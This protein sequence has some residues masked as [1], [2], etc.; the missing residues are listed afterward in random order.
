[1][2]VATAPPGAEPGGKNHREQSNIRI[3]MA[4]ASTTLRANVSGRLLS[5]MSATL[6]TIV[7][8]LFVHFAWKSFREK[9]DLADYKRKNARDMAIMG[10]LFSPAAGLAVL[11]AIDVFRFG[12]RKLTRKPQFKIFGVVLGRT[13]RIYLLQAF[14]FLLR[15]VW[16]ANKAGGWDSKLNRLAN[17]LSTLSSFSAWLLYY[18]RWAL[19]PLQ[20]S[21]D[22]APEIAARRERIR[23]NFIA[24]HAIVWTAVLGL[25]L[26]VDALDLDTEDDHVYD[27]TNVLLAVLF[28]LQGLAALVYGCPMARLMRRAGRLSSKWTALLRRLLGLVLVQLLCNAC[29]CIFFAWDPLAGEYSPEGTYPWFFYAVPELLPTIPMLLFMAP[30]A[31]TR[32]RHIREHNMSEM[33]EKGRGYH[34]DIPSPVPTSEAPAEAAHFKG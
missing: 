2:A 7:C 21:G 4:Q 20:S 8:A 10:W 14:S 28:F 27:W 15:V 19:A 18:H 13:R 9:E 32:S 1:L 26:W 3:S 6:T 29:R 31:Q 30:S 12:R 5:L 22:S 24:A 23:R 34:S 16:C 25:Y 17:R 33:V 11:L